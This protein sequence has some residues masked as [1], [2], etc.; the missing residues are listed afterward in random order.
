MRTVVQY[1]CLLVLSYNWQG[2]VTSDCSAV[3]AT[4]HDVMQMVLKYV[5]KSWCKNTQYNSHVHIKSS[6]FFLH[7]TKKHCNYPRLWKFWL[8]RS[9]AFSGLFGRKL[10]TFMQTIPGCHFEM[11]SHMVHW[12]SMCYK[13]VKNLQEINCYI[14]VDFWQYFHFLRHYSRSQQWFFFQW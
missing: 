7:M 9:A 11:W 4:V 2:I 14:C 13:I 8:Y 5:V 6:S 12:S 3:E 1:Q 10:R